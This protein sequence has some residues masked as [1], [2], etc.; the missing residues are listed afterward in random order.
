METH[1][2]VA[3]RKARVELIDLRTILPWDIETV[4]E[5]MNRTGRLVMVHE[6]GMTGGVLRFV[7]KYSSARQTSYGMGYEVKLEA[8]PS[9]T[10]TRRLHTTQVQDGCGH[11]VRD[12]LETWDQFIWK[13]TFPLLDSLSEEEG[14]A[15]SDQMSFSSAR[16]NYLRTTHYATSINEDYDD[17]CTRHRRFTPAPT[18]PMLTSFSRSVPPETDPLSMSTNSEGWLRGVLERESCKGLLCHQPRRLLLSPFW[19]DLPT[20]ARTP[21]QPDA[22]FQTQNDFKQSVGYLAN[23]SVYSLPTSARAPQPTTIQAPPPV[24]V[25][26]VEDTD[27]TDTLSVDEWLINKDSDACCLSIEAKRL[28]DGQGGDRWTLRMTNCSPHANEC[29][30]PRVD[31]YVNEVFYLAWLRDGFMGVCHVEGKT[32]SMAAEETSTSDLPTSLSSPNIPLY[33]HSDFSDTAESIVSLP[34]MFHLQSL[35]PAH[36]SFDFFSLRSLCKKR[37]KSVAALWKGLVI[38]R[39]HFHDL[40]RLSAIDGLLLP[41]FWTDLLTPAPA[42]TPVQPDAAF[43]TQND[44]EQ[45][46][47]YLANPSVY[48]LPT[49]AC[50]PVQPTAIQAPPPVPVITVEDTDTTDTICRC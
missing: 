29:S 11:V 38:R 15:P 28:C 48:S 39:V 46:A 37:R 14:V 23:P 17:N 27:T 44:F 45:S 25:I 8:A 36:R 2:P 41:P 20:P 4:V 18:S 1:A 9:P 32:E 3:L 16:I 35:L 19:I 50:A 34:T 21:V 7:R 13:V 12:S 24:P 10:P 40:K 49:S 42:R 43:Q 31:T 6:A 26:T 47:G 30:I 33:S 22:A 5:S